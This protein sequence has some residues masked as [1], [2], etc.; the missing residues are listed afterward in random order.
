MGPPILLHQVHLVAKEPSFQRLLDTGR[1]SH[2][3]L[4]PW[5]NTKTQQSGRVGHTCIQSVSAGSFGLD[6][7]ISSNL[8]FLY[9]NEGL[10]RRVG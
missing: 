7:R 10:R 8:M 5:K 1:D 4:V 6:P 9:L 3:T 2:S